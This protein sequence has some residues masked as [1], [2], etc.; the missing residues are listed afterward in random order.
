MHGS[1]SIFS[2]RTCVYPSLLFSPSPLSA[3]FAL[4]AFVFPCARSVIIGENDG[5][6]VANGSGD[7]ADFG[8]KNPGLVAKH[9]IVGSQPILQAVFEGVCII[10]AIPVPTLQGEAKAFNEVRP[11]LRAF[12]EFPSQCIENVNTSRIPFVSLTFR[13]IGT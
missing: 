1:S 3:T 13:E 9:T 5:R 7:D 12:K 11:P 4:T 6:G 10:M 2:G 8:G